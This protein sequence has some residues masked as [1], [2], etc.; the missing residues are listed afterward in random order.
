MID[1]VIVRRWDSCRIISNLTISE[2]VAGLLVFVHVWVRTVVSTKILVFFV[3]CRVLGLGFWDWEHWMAAHGWLGIGTVLWWGRIWAWMLFKE[4]VSLCAHAELPLGW[5][6]AIN[7]AR[8]MGARARYIVIP[9]I[10]EGCWAY[11][12][13]VLLREVPKH[14]GPFDENPVWFIIL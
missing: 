13:H 7:S 11:S 2:T 10:N 5:R 4:W 8:V 1:V 12:I 9:Y 6:I 3:P 14:F